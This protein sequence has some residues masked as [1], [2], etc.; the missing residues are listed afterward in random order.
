MKHFFRSICAVLLALSL[1][2]CLFSSA[3]AVSSSDIQDELDALEKRADEIDAQKNELQAQIDANDEK[4]VNVVDQRAQVDHEVTLIYQQ[5]QNLNEQLR[6]YNLLIAEKQAE[7]DDLQA[8]QNDLLEHYKQRLRA[9]QEQGDISYWAVI[10]RANSFSEMLNRISMVE[11]IAKSDQRM[12]EEIRT[13]ASDVL[14]AK[15]T[16]AAE[17]VTVEEKK[18][19][20]AAAEEELEAKRAE[21][22]KLLDELI[23]NAEL[24]DAD[25][26]KYDAMKNELAEEIAQKEKEYNDKVE[27]E[28]R[29][30]EEEERR[31]NENNGGN[32][33]GNTGGNTGGGG[34]TGDGSFLYPLPRSCGS[35][36][37]SPYGYRYH[38]ISGTYTF[39]SGVDLAAS[40]GTP[41]YA[42]KSGTVTTAAYAQYSWGNYVVINH[43]DGYSTLYAHM[44]Y[45][46]V[47]VGEHVNQGDVIGY[48]GTTGNSNGNH[49]HFNVYYNG[50]LQNPFDYVSVP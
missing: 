35:W 17:K 19:E 45:Y 42:S 18:T 7:L 25:M 9:M 5:V 6:Q 22:E 36:C 30:R 50:S 29:A 10:F 15:E 4:T 14:S 27:A 1:I 24:L 32:N 38:P 26:E 41:I 8:Q 23:A 48:V 33:G 13:L 3:F 31:N 16:L 43:G 46:A 12:M 49:L 40:G 47:S 34:T 37:T 21:S 44:R 11:E 20:L 39:H 28:R 2:A